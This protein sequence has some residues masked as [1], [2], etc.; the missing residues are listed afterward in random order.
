MYLQ[1]KQNLLSDESSVVY[2]S[3]DPQAIVA[4]SP[5]ITVTPTGRIIVTLD[6]SR[7]MSK[8]EFG[9]VVS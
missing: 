5:S 9:G 8:P 3:P 7:T 1:T 6:R 2:R 4:Y